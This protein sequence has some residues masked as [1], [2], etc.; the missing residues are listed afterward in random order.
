MTHTKA[1]KQASELWKSSVEDLQRAEPVKA[2]VVEQMAATPAGDRQEL[3]TH[4]IEAQ[5]SVDALTQVTEL[6]RKRSV[7]ADRAVLVDALEKATVKAEAARAKYLEA[8]KA[9]EEVEREQRA[10]ANR[11][12]DYVGLDAAGIEKASFDLDV[13]EAEA[14][15]ENSK[16][17]RQKDETGRARLNAEQALKTFDEKAV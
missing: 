17:N 11:G 14:K 8:H 16:T 9:L 6:L 5:A 1:A 13:R 10:L 2:A 3:L 12:R 4:Y 7:A 15:R